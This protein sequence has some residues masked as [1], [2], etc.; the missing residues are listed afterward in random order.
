MGIFH[1]IEIAC[2]YRS[3]VEMSEARRKIEKKNKSFQVL[4]LQNKTLKVNRRK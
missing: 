3:I 2:N 4:Q 1:N